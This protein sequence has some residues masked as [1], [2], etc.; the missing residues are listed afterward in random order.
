[1]KKKLT[2]NLGLKLLSVVS[3]IMLWLIV[4]NIDDAYTYRDY[5]NI[6]VTLL[7]D[8]VVTDQDMVYQVEEGTDII[9]VRVYAKRSVLDTLSS[10][11]FTATADM[12]K[13]IQYGNL[14]GIEVTCSNKNV[15]SANITKSRENVVL[16]IEE[17]ASEQFNVV[18][19]TSGTVADGYVVGSALPEQSLIEISG[20]ASVV[21][22]IDRVV[23]T[24]DVTGFNSDRTKTCS[25]TL[26]NAAGNE[27]DS[28]YLEYTG[29]T[30]GIDVTVTMLRTKTVSISL[31][32][33]TGEP[34]EGYKF[35][36]LSFKPDTIEIAGTTSDL[37]GVTSIEIPAEAVDIDGA[38]ESLSL[39][40]ELSQYLPD[41]LRLVDSDVSTVAVAVEIAEIVTQ[42][43]EIDVDDIELENLDDGFEVDF[44]DVDTIEIFVT[45]TEDELSELSQEDITVTLDLTRCYKAGTYTMT[46][47]V[48]L[49]DEVYSLG[50]DT[51]VDIEVVDT[52]SNVRTTSSKSA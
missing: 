6:Q 20:P 31:E 44:G 49:P 28:T 30:E 24:V 5:S 9:S 10:S 11:D 51:E 42:T 40:I 13:N 36:S 23:A 19:V 48:E 27:V 3:A 18:V 7:N 21:E 52:A 47:D 29:K 26:Y 8:Q 50:E 14:V 38:T 25:L 41:G 4:V 43:F 2:D 12:E 39:A 34:E 1:M 33:Y 35:I 32:G 15:D 46:V 16:S 37:S 45:G 22:E 17:A